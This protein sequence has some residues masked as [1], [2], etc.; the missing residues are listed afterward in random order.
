MLS[1]S[2][3]TR[4]TR[5]SLRSVATA[6]ALLADDKAALAAVGIPPEAAAKSATAQLPG[7]RRPVG[8]HHYQERRP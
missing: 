7:V 3:Q 5:L 8:L 4:T 1:L 2:E 6:P